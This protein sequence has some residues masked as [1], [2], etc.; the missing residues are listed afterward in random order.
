MK[1]FALLIAAALV[2]TSLV[3]CK[4]FSNPHGNPERMVQMVEK[5]LDKVLDSIDVTTE[6]RKTIDLITEQIIADAKQVRSQHA[7]DRG[8]VVACLLL[9]EPD[10]VWLHAKVDEKSKVWTEFSHRSI[11]RFMEISAVL[12][13]EQ[14]A[15]L[16]EKFDSAHVAKK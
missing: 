5:H 13:P 1:K 3:A 4:H 12:T 2:C 15:K 7:E 11:D 9:D 14:R 8:K 16:Q 6:Q 10:S